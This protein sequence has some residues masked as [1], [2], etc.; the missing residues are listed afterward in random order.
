MEQ[1]HPFD[2][3]GVRAE[4]MAQLGVSHSV[5]SNWKNR[6]APVEQCAAIEQATNGQVTRQELRPDDWHL[7][8]P[9][10]QPAQTA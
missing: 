9:E 10:L 6:G 7:I 5:L 4:I 2:K 8:W 1:I 3:P